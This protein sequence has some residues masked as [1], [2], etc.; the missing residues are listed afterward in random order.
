MSTLTAQVPA[1]RIPFGALVYRLAD[2]FQPWSHLDD[3]GCGYYREWQDGTREWRVSR[4]HDPLTVAVHGPVTETW[5]D[6]CGHDTAPDAYGRTH[7]YV[8]SGT[9]PAGYSVFA[10][11][12]LR[13]G[14][15]HDTARRLIADGWK[16]ADVSI[17]AF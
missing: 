12:N 10:S 1:N 13:H 7:S 15:A 16:R 11:R 2:G 8:V 14:D 4:S 17:E 9:T 3:R 5:C 6:D